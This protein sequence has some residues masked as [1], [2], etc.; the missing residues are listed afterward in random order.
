[1]IVPFFISLNLLGFIREGFVGNATKLGIG[2]GRRVSWE[3]SPAFQNSL[4][5]V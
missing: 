1:M 4:C 3:A 2:V 5:W